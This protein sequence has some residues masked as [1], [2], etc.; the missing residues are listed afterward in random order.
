MTCNKLL[1][2]ELH[3]TGQTV[4]CSAFWTSGHG[5]DDAV[6]YRCIYA[7]EQ[8][9]CD[10]WSQ[11]V[12]QHERSHALDIAQAHIRYVIE[13]VLHYR[14]GKLVRVTLLTRNEVPDAM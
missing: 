9:Q 2:D 11:R 4:D 3:C 12:H 10:A 13:C 7:D 6:M 8:H 14:Y 5:V 1:Q